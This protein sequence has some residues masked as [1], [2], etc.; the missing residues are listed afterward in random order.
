MRPADGGKPFDVSRDQMIRHDVADLTEPKFRELR[1]DP[2]FVGNRRR[3]DH[4][5]GGNAI[6][7]DQQKLVAK[8][9]KVSNLAAAVEG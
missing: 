1:E 2:A 9:I 6:T 7:G 8:I 3:Q 5:E 4:V